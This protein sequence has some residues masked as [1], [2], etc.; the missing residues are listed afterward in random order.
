MAITKG[1]KIIA[2]E[3][4]T[5]AGTNFGQNNII[6]A[7]DISNLYGGTDT[8]TRGVLIKAEHFQ[9][10][11][12]PGTGGLNGTYAGLSFKDAVANGYM[13][14]TTDANGWVLTFTKTGSNTLNFTSFGKYGSN[15]DIFLLGG[16]GAGNKNGLGG[17]GGFYTTINRT[18]STGGQ[19]LAIGAGGTSNGS[20]GGQTSAFSS[21]AKGGYGGKAHTVDYYYRKALL[22]DGGGTKIYYYKTWA[23]DSA[24]GRMNVYRENNATLSVADPYEGNIKCYSDGSLITYHKAYI[25]DAGT[26]VGDAYYLFHGV[27]ENLYRATN[28]SNQG[29]IETSIQSATRP[30]DEPSSTSAFGIITVSGSG[31]NTGSAPASRKGQGGG[32]TNTYGGSSFGI[33]G[34]GLIMIRNHR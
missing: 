23:Y 7:S 4:N 26:Y 25:A 27:D 31:S 19:T 10:L 14:Y 16:G 3:I 21:V 15:V 1:N 9:N 33:G 20:A 22:E 2:S 12:L 29:A 11:G 30:S 17:S 6:Y 32:G 18:L 24:N 13:S 34:N 5:S 8:I 28:V